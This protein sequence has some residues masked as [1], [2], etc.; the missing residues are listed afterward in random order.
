[1]TRHHLATDWYPHKEVKVFPLSKRYT[2]ALAC[3]L[4]MNIR[5]LEIVSKF[6]YSFARVA[7]EF[8]A[9]PINILGTP[10]NRAMEGGKVIRQE[11]LNVIRQ[12]KME[13]SEGNDANARDFLS[14]WLLD[15]DDDGT[16]FY[17]IDA[18]NK[19]MGLLIASYDTTAVLR[20]PS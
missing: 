15:G 18:T 19:I 10:F 17:D 16:I 8:I 7:P 11:L 6:A 5:D 13:I 2:S 4:F 12:R 9:V 3:R 14:R 1:M 20:S